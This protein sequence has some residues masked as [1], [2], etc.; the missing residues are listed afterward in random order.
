[1]S[2]AK[3]YAACL[4]I[5]MKCKVGKIVL[6]PEGNEKAQE[7]AR[8]VEHGDPEAVIEASPKSF[9]KG[10]EK[11][12]KRRDRPPKKAPEAEQS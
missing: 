2:I 1:M 7:F 9:V 12:P 6:T 10:P 3:S 11:V 8:L 5:R 4:G